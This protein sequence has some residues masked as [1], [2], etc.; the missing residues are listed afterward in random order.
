MNRH[1]LITFVLIFSI[2]GCATSNPG[3]FVDTSYKPSVD[4]NEE[5]L[6]D[7]QGESRQRWILYLIPIGDPPSTH[8]AITKAKQQIKGTRFLADI[9]IDEKTDW[10]FGYSEQIIIVN[11]QAYR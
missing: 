3:V 2:A 4:S 9:S 6:G 5:Y 11:A 1:F 10:S 7:V 8:E